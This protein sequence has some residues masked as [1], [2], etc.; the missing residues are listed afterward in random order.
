[1]KCSECGSENTPEAEV[2]AR[3]KTPLSRPED[4]SETKAFEQADQQPIPGIS[5]RKYHVI[6]KMGRGGMGEVY[7]AQDI[8]LGRTVALKFLSAGLTGTPEARTQF[9]KE[10]RARGYK[11]G[12][13]S[14][15]VKGGRCEACEGDGVLRIEMH[16]L[17][18]V[19]VPC[20]VC[21]GAR[22]NRD[23]LQVR[24]K[25]RTIAEVL[26]MT[27][28]DAAVFFRNIPSVSR[29]INTL[30]EVGLGYMQLGQAATTLSGGEAQ[31]VKLATDQRL[32]PTSIVCSLMRLPLPCACSDVA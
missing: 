17:P 1:M 23:T 13:F 6:R 28:E 27:I 29:V 25:G 15:N 14:F 3:C 10:A 5:P 11:A 20:E 12:R 21:G 16:F 32:V 30:E 9:V 4:L 26:D 24:Y 7:E 31:R 8:K 2:C 19:Y 18:D 22:Y